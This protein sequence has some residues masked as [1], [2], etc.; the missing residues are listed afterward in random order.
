[1]SLRVAVLTDGL[2]LDPLAVQSALHDLLL[3]VRVR[4]IVTRVPFV[5]AA[6]LARFQPHVV[7]SDGA[8][9]RSRL[10]T[11]Y[12]AACPRSRLLVYAPDPAR[13]GRAERRADGLVSG[14]EQVPA[15]IERLR[16][17]DRPRP[18]EVPDDIDLFAA[19]PRHREGEAAHRL[20]YVGD[21]SPQSGAADVFGGLCAWAER[22]AG[23]AVEIRWLGDGDL[24]GVLETQPLPPNVRQEFIPALTRPAL[25]ACF[26]ECG[27]L[28]APPVA[29][30]AVPFAAEAMAAGLI[31]LAARRA[32][33]R[34]RR[35]PD[36]SFDPTRPAEVEAAF[37]EVLGR[38]APELNAARDRGWLTLQRSLAG[39]RFPRPQGV[40]AV[41]T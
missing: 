13:R 29:D 22:N 8:G 14:T 40:A 12:R 41:P 37:T 19:C 5:A 7:V 16:F 3:P 39:G 4:R 18:L 11:L 6:E 32:G 15:A 2:E 17:S 30:P 28:V 31:V 21:L 36:F 1:M 23:R 27:I 26:A 34:R 24:L 38:T 10:A 25:A 20:L 35:A 33:G 9:A